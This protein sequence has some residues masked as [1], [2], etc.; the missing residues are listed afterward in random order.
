MTGARS[1]D[2][3]RLYAA[4]GYRV[5]GEATDSAGSARADGAAT[6]SA[7]GHGVITIP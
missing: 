3:L 2:D 6:V 4:A 1:D 7:P 5:V